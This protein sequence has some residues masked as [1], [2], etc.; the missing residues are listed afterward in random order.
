MFYFILSPFSFLFFSWVA[1][2][3]LS[4]FNFVLYCRSLFVFFSFFN[5]VIK[6]IAGTVLFPL[7]VAKKKNKN[8]KKQSFQIRKCASPSFCFVSKW[9]CYCFLRSS[10]LLPNQISISYSFFIFNCFFG[11]QERLIFFLMDFR[12]FT[13]VVYTPA[14]IPARVKH[15]FFDR[16]F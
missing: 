3:R 16:F 8:E 1:L 14:R 13:L 7:F 6:N 11:G 10:V 9:P 5:H 15:I 2:G 12:L 4:I